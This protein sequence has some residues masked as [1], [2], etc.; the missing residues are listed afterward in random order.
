MKDRNDLINEAIDIW[1]N[2][3]HELHYNNRFFAKTDI[4]DYIEQIA[5]LNHL[6]IN[7]GQVFYRARIY[8]DNMLNYQPELA[9]QLKKLSDN[10]KGFYGYGENDCGA[11]PLGASSEGRVN[12]KSITYLYL[13]DDE[14]TAVCEV[15]PFL[16]SKVS[17]AEFE[18]TKDI[19]IV[20]FAKL[21]IMGNET[22]ILEAIYTLLRYVYSMPIDNDHQDLYMPTQYVS[23]YI[24][25]LGYDGIKYKSSLSYGHN[26]ALFNPDNARALCSRLFQ[27]NQIRIKANC[28]NPN[29]NAFP[30]GYP[31]LP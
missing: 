29:T 25:K 6:V 16:K 2:F 8:N 20:D 22:T 27:V 17:V 24:K 7:N 15:R 19:K 23:E 12:P 5:N 21:D 3:R 1:N 18:L 9:H 30:K 26:F 4:L 31:L 28:I 14:Y 10:A 13:A 11:P